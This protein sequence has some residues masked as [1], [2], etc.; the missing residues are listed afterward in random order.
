MLQSMQCALATTLFLFCILPHNHCNPIQN[1]ELSGYSGIVGGGGGGNFLSFTT[2]ATTTDTDFD[3]EDLSAIK[4]FVTLGDSYAA[5]IGAGV[6]TDYKC[7]RYDHS[8]PALLST[9]QGLENAT[10]QFLACSGATSVDMLANQVP[11][12]TGTADAVR[13]RN[14]TFK[15]RH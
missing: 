3:P 12:I 6:R 11:A 9:Y 7:S 2:L 14:L 13:R 4:T 10:F 1:P 5:G 15:G 8:Y